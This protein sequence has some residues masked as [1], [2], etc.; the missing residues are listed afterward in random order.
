MFNNIRPNA[1]EKYNSF[2]WCFANIDVSY[3]EKSFSE[4]PR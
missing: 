3:T 1:R 4:A 2:D